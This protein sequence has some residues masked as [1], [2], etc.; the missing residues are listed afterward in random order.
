MW[1]QCAFLIHVL[2]AVNAELV[3]IREIVGTVA[4]LNL[5]LMAKLTKMDTTVENL[6]LLANRLENKM[7]TN[8]R[9]IAVLP[10]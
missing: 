10:I 1:V 2:T 6:V 5:A 3:S 7:E 9:K 4:D 8:E